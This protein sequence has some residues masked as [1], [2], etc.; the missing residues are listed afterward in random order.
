[1]R[2]H[3]PPSSKNHIDYRSAYFSFNTRPCGWNTRFI[4]NFTFK[5]TNT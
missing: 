4:C 3:L 2:D 1:M 5:T